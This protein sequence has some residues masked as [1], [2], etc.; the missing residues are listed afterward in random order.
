MQLNYKVENINDNRKPWLVLIN[1]LFAGLQSW[2]SSV[3]ELTNDFRVLRYDC[4]GQ[5]S[6]P[7]PPGPYTLVDHVNDLHKLLHNLRIEQCFL[8]GISNGG[9]IAMQFSK[10]FPE[11]VIAQVIADSYAK[12]S[13]LLKLKLQSWK[14]A[15]QIGGG[16]LRFKVA[17]PWIWGET[18]LSQNSELFEFYRQ[19]ANKEKSEVIEAL[20]DGALAGDIHLED[21]STPT[22]MLAGDED[23][24]T[25][26]SLHQKMISYYRD[27]KFEIV[28]GGHASLLEYPESIKERVIPYMKEYI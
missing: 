5:G 17:A 6:S 28:K 26:V 22:L 21:E 13:K 19:N 24:L 12:P 10:L 4:R 16:A 3:E 7:R 2:D 11:K 14:D 23:L 18:F 8:L 25:P 9:R 1:G 20:I 15:N 27:G